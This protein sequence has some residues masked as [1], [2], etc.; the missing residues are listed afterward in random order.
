[1]Q[2]NKNW[3]LRNLFSTCRT[4]VSELIAKEYDF[5]YNHDMDDAAEFYDDLK[6][7]NRENTGILLPLGWG[8]GWQSKTLGMLDLPR[9]LIK[10]IQHKYKLGHPDAKDFP[11]TRR[12][13]Q[14]PNGKRI[15]M[16][17]VQIKGIS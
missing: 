11:L 6:T 7:K 14:L 4:A 10:E 15:P 16:G 5:Y 13:Y 12:L 17:W 8:T 3:L 2:K 9:Q 1:M